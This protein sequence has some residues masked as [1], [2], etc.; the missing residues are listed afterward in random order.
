MIHNGLS[1]FF[2]KKLIASVYIKLLP[3]VIFLV[4][5]LVRIGCVCKLA[6]PHY[7]IKSKLHRFRLFCSYFQ[8][9]I[10]LVSLILGYSVD[11]DKYWLSE[12]PDYGLIYLIFFVVWI[13]SALTLKIDNNRHLRP[14]LWNH[15]LFWLL[16][17]IFQI[18]SF[19]YD[20]LIATEIVNFAL[21]LRN[22]CQF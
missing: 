7:T 17:F 21:I 11:Y 16:E 15:K 4:T 6:R 2:M 20:L 5:S 9:I 1:D 3:V 18:G 10:Y 12:S 14:A 22:S 13:Y 8:S 19:I